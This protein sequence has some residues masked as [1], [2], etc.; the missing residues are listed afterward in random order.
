MKS[1]IK[2]CLVVA[3][4]ART[5]SECARTDFWWAAQHCALPLIKR[6]GRSPGLGMSSGKG[7]SSC[8]RPEFFVSKECNGTAFVVERPVC[9]N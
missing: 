2:L 5:F 9:I 3:A 7:N 4:C 8:F 1:S 6:R